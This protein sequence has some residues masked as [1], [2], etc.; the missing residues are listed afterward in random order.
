[1]FKLKQTDT[2]SWPVTLRVAADGGKFNEEKFDL[3]FKRLPQKR[4]EELRADV[5]DDKLTDD[6]CVREIVCGWKG[7]TDDSGNELPFSQSSLDQLLQ[8]HGAGATIVMAFLDSLAG[9]LRKN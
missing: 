4:V 8:I 6:A 9:V 3:V 7:I 5:A 1:M 2:Y